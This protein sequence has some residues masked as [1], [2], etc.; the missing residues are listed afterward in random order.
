MCSTKLK[1]MNGRMTCKECGYYVRNTATE[2]I[3]S[4]FN[5]ST[6][7]PPTTQPTYTNNPYPTSYNPIFSGQTGNSY[8]GINSNTKKKTSNTGLS[9]AIGSFVV[10][11]C[12]GLIVGTLKS[13]VS[14]SVSEQRKDSTSITEEIG[15]D[16]S[17]NDA[18]TEEAKKELIRPISSLLPNNTSMKYPES[19][20][21]IEMSE[22]IWDKSYFNITPEE[23][24]SLTALS[25][26]RSDHV[27]YYEFGDQGL[28]SLTFA[29]G[30]GMDFEDLQCF[31]GLEWLSI[32]TGL[33]AGDLDGLTNLYAVHT[34]NTIDE[35]LEIIPNPQS[36]LELSV[37]DSIFEESLSGIEQFPNL[38]SLSV[39][40]SSLTDISELNELPY[41]CELY[42]LD[43]NDLTDYSPL[44]N[45]TG[46]EYLSIQSSQ[47][48]SIDFIQV[49]PNLTGL[50]IE[51]SQI[52]KLDAL[53]YCPNLTELYLMDN[54]DV[55]DYSVIGKLTE[56]YSLTFSASYD[57]ILPSLAAL[58][59]L[60]ELTM[61]GVR[62]ISLLKDAVNVTYLNMSY[63]S[64]WELE[65][66]VAMQ[67]LNT[68]IIN[69]F[70]SLTDDI[71]PLTQLPKLEYL[72]LTDTSIFGNMEALFGITT[73]RHLYLDGCQVGMDFD[74]IPTN[75]TLEVLS[76]NGI[77]VLEDP[78]YNSGIKKNIAEQA[79]MF[80][81]F[82]NLY[83]LYVAS[84]ELE[85]IDFVSS[86]PNLQY[87]DITDNSITS[88]KPLES[89]SNFQT[90]WCAKNTILETLPEDSP[91]QVITSDY[92]YYY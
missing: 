35:Y 23:Y 57:N 32:D 67:E 11:F 33:Y 26:N 92:D 71:T 36:I 75:D 9:V 1:M 5:Y 78:S 87:L 77:R 66:I 58:T 44:L 41:L 88:L 21:F 52:S 16:G 62:D 10:I 84:L 64:G 50:A 91:V 65:N 53:E 20:F 55:T 60:E 56:L 74:N 18:H 81:K 49:M 69:D 28:Q 24:G 76:M 19:D 72:D 3:A 22:V 59:N 34:E 38:K 48:K 51:D 6:T 68:L 82:P 17:L 83:E 79:D 29:D 27:I 25:I 89:L 63:C 70:A 13:I 4:N 43:C 39:E 73:L 45:L 31:T 46:L 42:L 7:T 54:Y 37:E 85:N 90:V 47:L 86:L 15:P 2:N 61:D 14:D 80:T 8:Q 40:Y 12:I 30:S